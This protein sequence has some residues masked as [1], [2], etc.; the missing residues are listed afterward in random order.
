MNKKQKLMITLIIIFIIFIPL[1]LYVNS[2][3]WGGNPSYYWKASLAELGTFLVG[4][5]AGYMIA[6]AK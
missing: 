5:C 2:L 6:K 1:L 4:I 3:L